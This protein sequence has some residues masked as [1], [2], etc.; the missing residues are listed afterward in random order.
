[1]INSCIFKAYLIYISYENLYFV[2]IYHYLP[3]N[4]F[5]FAGNVHAQSVVPDSSQYHIETNDGNTFTGQIVE[6]DAFKIILRTENLG[7]L[8]IN[9]MEIRKMEKI[10]ALKMKNGKY[11]F[12]N[13]KA[14]RYFYSPKGYGLK[15]GEGYY[16]NVWV[17]VNSFAVGVSDN[18]SIGAGIVPLFLFAGTATPVWLT[19]KVSIPV[20]A[21]SVN[22]GAGALIGGVIGGE[23]TGFGILYGISTFGTKDNKVSFGLG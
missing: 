13:P 14:T 7:D 20:S 3:G 23:G 1:M 17:L 11:W 4:L 15:S 18:I 19:P 10:N 6:K 5:F 2:S 21:S 16:Q 9:R 22:L 8:T 12:D